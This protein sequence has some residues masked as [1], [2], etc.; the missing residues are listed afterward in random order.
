MTVDAFPTC[1]TCAVENKPDCYPMAPAMWYPIE[2]LPYWHMVYSQ[3][4]EDL[5]A[6]LS[7]EATS[8]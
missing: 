3:I 8:L 7:M 4:R 2:D 1:P 6:P 5:E